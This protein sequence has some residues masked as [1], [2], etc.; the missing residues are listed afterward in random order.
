MICSNR[1]GRSAVESEPT[2]PLIVPK[3]HGG[4]LMRVRT[5]IHSMIRISPGRIL[6][7]LL[8]VVLAWAYWPTLSDL[9]RTWSRDSRY[10]HGYLVP[11]FALY[12]LW[13]RRRRRSDQAGSSWIGV[14]LIAA[15]ASLHFLGAYAYFAWLDSISLL[16]SLAGLCA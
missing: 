13:L 7:V 4:S 2:N 11:A 10:S 8:V 15:G 16:V 9:E 14:L 3:P 1:S 5:P 12:L 6:A